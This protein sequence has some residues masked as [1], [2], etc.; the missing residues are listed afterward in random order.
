MESLAPRLGGMDVALHL[1]L[2]QVPTA[3]IFISNDSAALALA[4][5]HLP[6]HRP[7]RGWEGRLCR[8]EQLLGLPWIGRSKRDA[9]AQFPQEESPSR[10]RTLEL[11]VDSVSTLQLPLFSPP[12]QPP[13]LEPELPVPFLVQSALLLQPLREVLAK[14]GMFFFQFY[15]FIYFPFCWV[16]IAKG[17]SLVAASRG[18]T[19]VAMLGSS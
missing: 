9:C 14:E 16:S 7:V 12:E 19:L 15:L 13:T 6:R 3:S 2:L 11:D 17:F 1:S 10:Q 18:Y 5:P 4:V 8:R